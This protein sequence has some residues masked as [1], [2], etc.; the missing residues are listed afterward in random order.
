MCVAV[1]VVDS[2][3]RVLSDTQLNKEKTSFHLCY[4][5]LPRLLP[6][7]PALIRSASVEDAG[8]TLCDI[9]KSLPFMP[10]SASSRDKTEKTKFFL[11][12][13]HRRLIFCLKLS[14]NSPKNPCYGS[15]SCGICFLSWWKHFTCFSPVTPCW[16]VAPMAHSVTAFLSFWRF[17][18]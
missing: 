10:L 11:L 14:L 5:F 17:K 4:L 7:H 15:H 6:T 3:Q 9:N 13:F 2:P 12:F 8:I 16:P 18:R 1:K